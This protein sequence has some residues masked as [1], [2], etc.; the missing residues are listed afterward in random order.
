MGVGVGGGG[1]HPQVVFFCAVRHV[2]EARDMIVAVAALLNL[3]QGYPNISS[4]CDLWF[5]RYDLVLEVI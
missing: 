5:V 2:F 4:V 3:L 1:C